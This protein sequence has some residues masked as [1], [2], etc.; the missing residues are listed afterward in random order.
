MHSVS[1]CM[2]RSVLF[3]VL[4]VLCL[5]AL[6]SACDPEVPVHPATPPVLSTATIAASPE[7][8]LSPSQTPRRVTELPNPSATLKPTPTPNPIFVIQ[9][10]AFADAI[11]GWAMGTESDRAGWTRSTAAVMRATTDGG[12]TWNRVAAPSATVSA[13]SFERNPELVSKM[14]FANAQ[15]GWTF[16]TGLYSTHDGAMTWQAEQRLGAIVAIEPKDGSIWAI[17]RACQVPSSI[18][19]CEFDLK[20]SGDL[21]RTWQSLPN[22]PRM[23]GIKVQLVR[24]SKEEAYIYSWGPIRGALPNSGEI[25]VYDVRLL[26]KTTDE[27]KTWRELEPPMGLGC[28]DAYLSSPS[29]DILW[30]LCAGDQAAGM[31][32]KLASLSQDGGRSWKLVTDSQTGACGDDKPKTQSIGDLECVGYV[33]TFAAQ[34]EERVFVSVDQIGLFVTSDGGQTWDLPYEGP[35]GRVGHAQNSVMFIDSLHGWFA[36]YNTVARTTDGGVT[37]EWVEVR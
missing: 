37:W 4:G 3:S 19:Q 12:E 35:R 29:K 1:F 9:S 6:V 13:D 8:S 33:R 34:S 17:E 36:D 14:K 30:F 20:N 2:F 28:R 22:Q 26:M 11:H 16:D 25:G 7:P 31:Q 23:V 32:V 24:A 27:G 10:L 18:W 15:A 5:V 21:G